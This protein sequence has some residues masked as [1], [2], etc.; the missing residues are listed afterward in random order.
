MISSMEKIKQGVLTRNL[1]Q[2]VQGLTEKV[3][4]EG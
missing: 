1:K 2:S 4:L 3:T